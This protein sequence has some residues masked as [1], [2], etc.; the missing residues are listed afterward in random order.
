M[1]GWPI[2]IVT[3][4][5]FAMLVVKAGS[6]AQP[7]PAH[8]CEIVNEAAPLPYLAPAK[9]SPAVTRPPAKV[10]PSPMMLIA[11]TRL[12]PTALAGS[13]REPAVPSRAAALSQVGA[14][15]WMPDVVS[16]CAGPADRGEGEGAGHRS[17]GCGADYGAMSAHAA[18]VRHGLSRKCRPS[19]LRRSRR[20]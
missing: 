18:T 10:R 17:A 1:P 14:F 2:G 19:R 5:T 15:A 8:F 13:Q 20:G 4:P 16:P 3:V 9:V 12:R 6:A 11:P 7:V